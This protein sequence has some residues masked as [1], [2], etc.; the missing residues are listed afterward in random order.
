MARIRTGLAS[1]FVLVC[2]WISVGWAGEL[3]RSD[4]ERFFP[5]PYILGEKDDVLPIWPIFKQN[6]TADKLVAYV[7]ESV[8]LAPIPGFSGAPLDLLVALTPEGDFLDVKVLSHH[9]PVFVDGLGSEPLFDFVRQ[10][11]G[12]SLK[13]LIRVGPPR[14]GGGG[15]GAGA[16]VNGVA[17]ATASVRIVN[18]SLLAAGLAVARARNSD[19]WRGAIRA[20][21][22]R[23]APMSSSG[24]TGP[25]WR[26][27]ATFASMWSTT[28]SRKR[29]SPGRTPRGSIRKCALALVGRVN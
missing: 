18:E 2:A 12:K 22:R 14:G 21:R 29:R 26:L 25:V 16:V 6:G 10:Y 13:E 8:D 20:A 24:W 1:A 5:P 15:D 28:R 11:T 4:L 9:E 27:E 17:K 3:Q 19:S 7:F 23:C